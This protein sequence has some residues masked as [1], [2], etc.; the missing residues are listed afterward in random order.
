MNSRD[1]RD[2]LK[3]VHRTSGMFLLNNTFAEACAFLVGYDKALQG[4]LLA[5]F[6]DWL[7][8]R[9]NGRSNLVFPW[10]VLEYAAPHADH[11]SLTPEQERLA[12]DAL[13]DLLDEYLSLG[14]LE[15]RVATATQ[16]ANSRRMDK[17]NCLCCGFATMRDMPP[18][19][20]QICQVCFWHDDWL[21]AVEY[22]RPVG[23]NRVGLQTARRNFLKF[24]AAEKRV[25]GFVRE[26]SDSEK[27]RLPIEDLP[28]AA[29]LLLRTRFPKGSGISAVNELHTHLSYWSSFVNCIVY[30]LFM[31]QP[32]L[33]SGLDVTKGLRDIKAELMAALAE[34]EFPAKKLVE[35]YLAYCGLV[36]EVW[37][38]AGP[39]WTGMEWVLQSSGAI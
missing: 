24:G 2:F 19:T 1:L 32:A 28:S 29:D 14:K 25:L 39:R 17:F 23:P 37:H 27:P 34:S 5:G 20:H 30:P 21:D 4:S 15:N 33:F 8:V 12:M 10:L 13:F 9:T 7:V 36:I 18:G 6:R 3:R 31:G 26:P 22:T 11:E 38:S 35:E 16:I